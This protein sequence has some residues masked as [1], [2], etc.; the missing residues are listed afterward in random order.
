MD[1][2]SPRTLTRQ[3]LARFL[4]SHELVKAFEALFKVAGSTPDE[5]NVLVGLVGTAQED[6]DSARAIA[7]VSSGIAA[8]ALSIASDI[9][10]GPPVVQL[11]P[12]AAPDDLSHIIGALQAQIHA[13]TQRVS[14]LEESPTP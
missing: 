6:A 9:N 14:A 11:P 7:A 10:D 8:L 5:I 12:P 4:P 13:L 2:L 1:E 3:Q